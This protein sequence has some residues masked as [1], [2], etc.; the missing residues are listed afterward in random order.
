MNTKST[1]D[2]IRDGR[3]RR[4]NCMDRAG[5]AKRCATPGR[6]VLFIVELLTRR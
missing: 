2:Y 3:K 5:Y 1:D 4:N 6:E